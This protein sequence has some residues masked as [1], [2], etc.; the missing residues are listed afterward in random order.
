MEKSRSIELTESMIQAGM[1]T[2]SVEYNN[3]YD[4]IEND[5]RHFVVRIYLSMQKALA[6]SPDP[7]AVDIGSKS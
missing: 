5:A 4:P 2:L 7:I 6:Q 1:K 3:A